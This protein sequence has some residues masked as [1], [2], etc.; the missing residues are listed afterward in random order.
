[1]TSSHLT[2]FH[3]HSK[4]TFGQD[5]HILASNITSR[6]IRYTSLPD[7]FL[8][9]TLGPPPQT[10]YISGDTSPTAFPHSPAHPHTL[11][12]MA[13]ARALFTT[14]P[15]LTEQRRATHNTYTSH[16]TTTTSFGSLISHA[17]CRSPSCTGTTH[18]FYPL[19]HTHFPAKPP[20]FTTS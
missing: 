16:A 17:N 11:A 9:A 13:A 8:H 3:F 18:S 14:D 20:S 6:R 1:M 19:K 4:S 7:T 12:A 10:I 15:I 2:N 5:T